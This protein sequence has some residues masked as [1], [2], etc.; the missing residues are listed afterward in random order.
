MIGQTVLHYKIIEKLGEGGMGE[1]YKAKDT[2]LDRFVALKFLPSQMT[3]SE[4]D[5]T[6]FIQE[7]KAASAMNH[8]NVCTIYSI[9]E[10]NERL[11]IA[12]EYVE[13]RTL[14]DKKDSLSEKQILEIGI[15]VAEGLAAAHEKGIVHRDI[16]PEN[17]MVR[18]D[19]ITQILDFGLA[20]LQ[21]ASGVSRLTKAGT[22]MGT[23]GY[24]SP[25]QVQGLDVDHRTDIFSLG[26][27][28]YELLAGESPFKGIHETAM[29][30]E[31]VN[32]EASP[33]STFKDGIDP[34]LDNIILECLEKDKDERCQSA[35]ELAKDL[36]KVK[37]S[38][39]HRKSRF[40][41]T[42]GQ[43]QKNTSRSST[44]QKNISSGSWENK[45]YY[46]RKISL[47]ISV[48]LFIAAV[49]FGLLYFLKPSN[50]SKPES[51]S[52]IML[53]AGVK[54]T[55][56]LHGS[57]IAISPDGKYIT[58]VGTDISGAAKL[59][60]RPLN[61][62]RAK[63]IADA[64]PLSFPFWSPDSKFIAYFFE[65]K[66]NKISIEG[67][68]PITICSASGGAGGTWNRTGTIV[69]I[70]N[71]LGGLYKVSADGGKPELLIPLSKNKNWGGFRWPYFLP[72]GKHFLFTTVANGF[73]TYEQNHGAYE[74]YAASTEAPNP[75]LI[76]KTSSNAQYSKGYLFFVKQKILF[77]RPF[78]TGNFK[79][80]GVS[81]PIAANV[82]YYRGDAGGVFSVSVNG[83]II[84]QQSS[85][86]RDEKVMLL[87]KKGDIKNSLF[88]KNVRYTTSFSP[89]D[90]MIAFDSYNNKNNSDIWIYNISRNIASRFTFNTASDLDPI[91]SPD[92]KKI[93]FSSNRNKS[94]GLYV[95]NSDGSGT[96]KPLFN[97]VSKNM[98]LAT[99]WSKDGRYVA[100][101]IQ[102]YKD[103]SSLWDILILP[104]SGD[105]KPVNFLVTDFNEGE[106]KFSPDGKWIA[107]WSNQSG[108]YQIY[109]SPFG[110]GSKWQVSNVENLN[111]GPR[112]V[113][114]GKAIYFETSD[115]KVWGVNVNENGNK[116]SFGNPY[117]VL[118]YNKLGKNVTIYDVNKTGDKFIAG[119]SSGKS[120][121]SAIT[122]I[123]NWKHNGSQK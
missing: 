89:D 30:Y 73:G 23:M 83:T 70:P 58:F 120:S 6:R 24:M 47:F 52:G 26:V 60:L 44:A 40:Y 4:E 114:D 78:D 29:M 3:A 94:F 111:W 42:R 121:A 53:P 37:R 22:T 35:K 46:N 102:S 90:K 68:Q 79:L 81:I 57:N 107:Y 16:K 9:E 36:R 1:V 19:G 15:Q 112:W 100:V 49:I 101:M 77:A 95:K 104:A 41:N 65:G 33:L 12:M 55:N 10:Y 82:Q 69:F 66:L 116:L 103:K 92:D 51:R 122:M 96:V 113:K 28:L 25:E 34:E 64:F 27:I 105:K 88:T 85:S 43:T 54:L 17:I 11:F 14:K 72:D 106:P 56:S 67:G 91:W 99:D 118:D 84:Y 20:K 7:A 2:K 115:N 71:Y 87:N 39:G 80:T 86:N 110:G 117:V 31:I 119:I 109:V 76:L 13:G 5:K 61:S 123:S 93:I 32:V 59:W 18:K 21:E 74:I 45:N 62:L 108:K 50:L 38:S 63:P 8:P 98:I 75:Q 48:S 97:Q